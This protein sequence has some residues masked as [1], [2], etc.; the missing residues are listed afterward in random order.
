MY[1]IITSILISRLFLFSLP[2]N[3]FRSADSATA[4]DCP[5]SGECGPCM[6]GLVSLTLQYNGPEAVNILVEDIQTTYLSGA[7][8]P[9]Q[10]FTV[11]GAGNNG[12]F[13]GNELRLIINGS[14]NAT[15][16]VN[17]SMTVYAHSTFGSFIVV[18]GVSK[19]GG[20]LCCASE[21]DNIFPV[22]SGCPKDT[23]VALGLL[24]CSKHIAWTIP[25][26]T[27][28]C[29]LNAFTSTHV[30]G[31]EFFT[32]TTTVEYFAKDDAGN[33]ATCA[34][35]V[36]VKDNVP[37]VAGKCPSDLMVQPDESGV[38]SVNWIA[39]VFSDNCPESSVTSTHQPGDVFT[40]GTTEVTYTAIDKSGNSS[41]CTF[42]VTVSAPDEMIEISKVITPDDNGI[43]DAWLLGN[44]EK[45]DQSEVIVVDRW[46]SVV[47]QV[48]GY[49]NQDI[50]WQGRNKEGKV[51]P[52]GTY[53]YTIKLQI[54]LTVI[55]KRG[56][57]ELVD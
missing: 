57:V 51:L 52:A 43:N 17:C 14:L 56:F 34:F 29:S 15:I 12:K 32:G 46:G 33:T 28:N 38:A 44:I 9:G 31:E 49:N 25:I 39:P 27:D 45:Y 42:K 20:A 5:L 48:Q 18:S 21:V 6:G 24:E 41:V 47:Y 10:I 1:W 2:E 35:R 53:F 7:V 36:T 3:N 54:D 23:V 40:S 30:P 55:E 13:Q 50:A 26:A 8:N 11:D 19:E 22:I 4:C 37:P 16:D